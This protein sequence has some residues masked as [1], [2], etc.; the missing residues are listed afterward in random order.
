MSEVVESFV[1]KSRDDPL[2]SEIEIRLG[3]Y[4]DG[5]FHPGVTRIMF[6][7]LE[8]DMID[9]GTLQAERGWTEVV[10]YFYTVKRGR[11]VRTRVL[12]DSDQMELSREHLTKEARTDVVF[13]GGPSPTD[14]CRIAFARETPVTDPPVLCMP[15]FVRIKQRRRFLDLR[16]GKVVWSYE[17]SKTWSGA[18]RSAVEHMQHNSEPTYE[19]E[20]ELVDSEMNYRGPRSDR[21]VAAS[22]CLK[23]QLLLGSEGVLEVAS[24]C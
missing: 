16:D 3:T 8:R 4:R 21:D 1:R 23:A 12:F 7:Q 6:E 9:S 14:A 10:D 2:L 13:R 17:F 11:Q 5:R 24:E 18:S 22:L 19:I 20:C 15:T